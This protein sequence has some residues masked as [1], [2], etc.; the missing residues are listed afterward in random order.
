MKLTIEIETDELDL[1][2]LASA[3]AKASKKKLRLAGASPA[4]S[5]DLRLTVGKLRAP[6]Q[7]HVPL[8]ASLDRAECRPRGSVL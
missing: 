6:S 3:I 1:I 7:T 2:S 5:D 8:N 4:P